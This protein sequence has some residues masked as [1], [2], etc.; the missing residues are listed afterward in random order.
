M[1]IMVSKY[2]MC[3]Q[4]HRSVATL[5][6]L[7]QLH[8]PFSYPCDRRR[9]T[10]WGMDFLP[11]KFRPLKEAEAEL[12]DIERTFRAM[13]SDLT[14]SDRERVTAQLAALRAARLRVRLLFEELMR[15]NALIV[16]RL[17]TKEDGSGIGRNTPPSLP[18]RWVP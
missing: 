13:S 17:A 8:G 3:V 15:E 11:H 2:C 16:E 1:G 7:L 10:T 18:D 14:P 9:P 12:A 4:F 6:H 5:D